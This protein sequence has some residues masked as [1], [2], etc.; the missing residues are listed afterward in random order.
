[1]YFILFFYILRLLN[2]FLTVMLSVCW[3][4]SISNNL[5]TYF[6][7]L[8]IITKLMVYSPSEQTSVQTVKNVQLK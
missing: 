2:L 5:F 4:F 1:M 6:F 7:Y 8:N 3:Y